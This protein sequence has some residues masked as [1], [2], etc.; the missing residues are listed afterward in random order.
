MTTSGQID[1]HWKVLK[2]LWALMLVRG[3]MARIGPNPLQATVV[4]PAATTCV[5]PKGLR[6]R[7]MRFNELEPPAVE[8]QSR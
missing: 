2:G 3:R 6:F 8:H 1:G 7:H 4:V 5:T